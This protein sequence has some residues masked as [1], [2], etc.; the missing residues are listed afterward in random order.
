MRSLLMMV[1]ALAL[2]AQ[3]PVAYHYAEDFA[4]GQAS[5]WTSYPPVQDV[6]YDPSLSPLPRAGGGFSMGRIVRPTRDGALEIGF[7]RRMSFVT[8][9]GLRL[10]F[11]LGIDPAGT[12][13]AVEVG[14][15]ARSGVLHRARATPGAVRLGAEYFGVKA[16]ESVEAVYIVARIEHASA[17]VE[18]TLRLDEVSLDAL[19][20][21]YTPVA[22]PPLVASRGWEK[23]VAARVYAYG[24]EPPLKG[25]RLVAPDGTPRSAAGRF[26]QGDAPGLWEAQLPDGTSFAFLLVGKRPGAHPRVF[27]L[28][29]LRSRARSPEFAAA[30]KRVCDRAARSRRDGALP[31]WAGEN[32]L[33]LYPDRLLPALMSYFTVLDRTADL[34]LSNA[35]VA[36]VD[37]NPEARE[38]ARKALLTAAS[39]PTWTPPWFPAHGMHTYYQAG[40]FTRNIAL[41]YDLS[42]P[43]L[44]EGERAAVRRALRELGTLPTFREHFLDARM[45]FATSNW[46][47]NSLSGAIVATA[48][49]GG[50]DREPDQ[51][52]LLTGLVARLREHVNETILA[53]GSSGEPLGYEDFDLEG[54]SWSM[55]ALDRAYG[56]DFQPG[57]ALGTA[58]LYALYA[59]TSARECPDM[60]DGGLH[61]TRGFAWLARRND[62]ARLRRLYRSMPHEP[63]GELALGPSA[64]AGAEAPLPLSRFFD[65]KGAIV[66]RGGWQPEATVLAFRAGPNFNHNH[67]DAGGFLLSAR[68]QALL[69]EA[70]V[71]HYYNDPHYASHFIQAAGHNVMLVDG[72]PESQ[73][74]PDY[75]WVKAL[76]RRPRW[77]T[78]LLADAADLFETELRAVYKAPLES[79]RRAVIF[80]R[81]GYFVLCDRVSAREEHAFS[82]LFHPPAGDARLRLEPG[83]FA[84]DRSAASLRATLI[85]TS[86]LELRE[87]EWPA[88]VGALENL[89][90]RKLEPW[91]YVE[92]SAASGLSTAFVAV[93][94]PLG[95]GKPGPAVT[96]IRAPG[97]L[98][99]RVGDAD[100]VAF[101]TGSGI[102]TAG[103]VQT[104][105]D[106][107]FMRGSAAGTV[108]RL[109]VDR[110]TRVTWRGR[111]LLSAS[112][113]VSVSVLWEA[114]V[115]RGTVR[116]ARAAEVVLAGT[117]ISA[118][119]GETVVPSPAR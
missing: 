65:R 12:P 105:G 57:T 98:G 76:D 17:A 32:I 118:Q 102:L 37:D 111:E 64:A 61:S 88:P 103:E 33:R 80:V 24:D 58:H 117:R 13:A 82:W 84:L 36:A 70:G 93:L 19:R 45:P 8:G 59:Q 91:K 28:S 44:S 54:V 85:A 50:E 107:I 100:I 94:C 9:P 78:V 39:W 35:L 38:A 89:T 97:A 90:A 29:E 72:N 73:R 34:A 15:S 2:A 31:V 115:P 71:T 5:G 116:A 25:A 26:Q 56:I 10:S 21:P 1:P 51:P 112:A 95:P 101:R 109:T 114:G 41:A 66:L 47:G 49:T 46:I 43:Y 53:D 62:D 69:S 6:A 4:S 3:Q 75:L 113:P 106:S 40:I 22:G 14:L 77:G 96:Q 67:M 60:G 68:G 42:Y 11:R 104:D 27:D 92:A 18:Y 108:E 55:G 74:L 119:A 110:A 87:H 83:G 48:A 99:V 16:G 23:R 52:G 63:A 81:P 7:L 20:P 79:Y 30:W 86:P